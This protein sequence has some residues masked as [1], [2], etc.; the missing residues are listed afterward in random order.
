[1]IVDLILVAM[2]LLV[3]FGLHETRKHFIEQGKLQSKINKN[4][5]DINEIN[6]RYITKILEITDGSKNV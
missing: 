1:M 5:D 3:S 2:I 4:Q 6:A